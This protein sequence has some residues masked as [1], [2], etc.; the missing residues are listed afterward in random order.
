[1]EPKY[2]KRPNPVVAPPPVLPQS[3][4]PQLWYNPREDPAT[5]RSSEPS[6]ASGIPDVAQSRPASA[7]AP[8]PPPAPPGQGGSGAGTPRGDE[9]ESERKRG[10]DA[11]SRASSALPPKRGRSPGSSIYTGTA[12]RVPSPL[13][14]DSTHVSSAVPA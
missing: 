1:M 12:S 3:A 4:P 14:S 9:T 10:R 6:A 8:P 5:A 11:G 7:R 13:G 2:Q